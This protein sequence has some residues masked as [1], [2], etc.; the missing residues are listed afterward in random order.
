MLFNSHPVADMLKEFTVSHYREPR[1]VLTCDRD[2]H[3]L[4]VLWF[5]DGCDAASCGEE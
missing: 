5:D 4:D 3:D 2:E 1:E